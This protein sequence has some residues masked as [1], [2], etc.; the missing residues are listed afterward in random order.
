MYSY[1]SLPP[2][3][4]ASVL[5]LSFPIPAPGLQDCRRCYYS[6]LLYEYSFSI[7]N[8]HSLCVYFVMVMPMMDGY[9]TPSLLSP[10]SLFVLLLSFVGRVSCGCGHYFRSSTVYICGTSTSPP[11]YCTSTSAGVAQSHLSQTPPRLLL[12]CTRSHP[13]SSDLTCRPC[14]DAIDPRT[15]KSFS[16]K[17]S[18]KQLRKHVLSTHQLQKTCPLRCL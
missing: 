9:C 16:P 11:G 7:C 15:N 6:V 10:L 13:T 12:C 18:G 14:H 8:P 2:S 5:V 4:P 3:R 1:Y 17:G